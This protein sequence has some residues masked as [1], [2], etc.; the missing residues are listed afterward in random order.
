[1]EEQKKKIKKN[2]N[3]HENCLIFMYL[4]KDY[5]RSEKKSLCEGNMFRFYGI[6]CAK[7]IQANSN[8]LPILFFSLVNGPNFLFFFQKVFYFSFTWHFYK[9]KYELGVAHSLR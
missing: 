6:L 2:H 5:P 4:Y 7:F 3:K 1:M 9:E 8:I